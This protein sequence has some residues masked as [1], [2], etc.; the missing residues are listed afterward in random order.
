[1]SVGGVRGRRLTA[2]DGREFAQALD[3][4]SD[5]GVP[6]GTEATV[7]AGAGG[8]TLTLFAR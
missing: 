3:A 6:D 7:D 4:Y 5:N 1:M 8:V 2:R